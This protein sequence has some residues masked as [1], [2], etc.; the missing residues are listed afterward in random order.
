MASE[1]LCGVPKV[2]VGDSIMTFAAQRPTRRLYRS[3]PGARASLSLRY[4][5]AQTV[6]TV[7][8]VLALGVGEGNCQ[9]DTV[10]TRAYQIGSP[11]SFIRTADGGFAASGNDWIGLPERQD[12]DFYLGKFDSSGIIEWDSLYAGT[13]DSSNASD[14][15]YAVRQMSDNGFV[16]TGVGWPGGMV[17]RTD[18]TGRRQWVKYLSRDDGFT[19]LFDCDLDDDGNIVVVQYR[20]VAKL[21]DARQGEVMWLHTYGEP[22]RMELRNVARSTDGGFLI[23]GSTSSMGAGGYDMYAGKINSDGELEWENAYGYEDGERCSYAIQNTDGGWL[24]V[25][26]TQFGL[27]NNVYPM[28]V[29]VDSNGNEIWKRTYQ[30]YGIGD[31]LYGA[32]QTVD[33]GFAVLGGG[34]PFLLMRL[35]PTGEL[36]WG[37]RLYPPGGSAYGQSLI[38]MADNSYFLGGSAGTHVWM[39]RT[40]PDPLNRNEVSLLDPAFPSL[41]ALE[42]PYPN[43]FNSSTRIAYTLATPSDVH[44]R[45]Y[46]LMGW[47]V[48]T[49]FEGRQMAGGHQALWNGKN[50]L[51]A[52]VSSGVYFV[53]L[54]TP[55][56]GN[57]NRIVIE[58]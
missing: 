57:A 28:V 22:G 19:G 21:S 12:V 17:V 37:T 31:Y 49:L 27:G 52:P 50:A 11:V 9:P 30:D 18:S 43:P 20:N 35:S 29:R 3:W 16:I 58:R 13:Y 42:A 14:Q 5:T 46:D 48:A 8:A 33:S 26:I 7:C 45:V 47:E 39:V 53:R 6:I 55:V 2:F 38:L 4:F 32:V 36:L 56:G 54:E 25:G 44:L 10:W 24:L 1:E 51:G 41:I 40:E 15:A 23:T 34:G